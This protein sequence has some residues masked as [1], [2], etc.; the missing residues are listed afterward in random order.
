MG[1][2]LKNGKGGGYRTYGS[3]VGREIHKVPPRRIQLRMKM[4]AIFKVALKMIILAC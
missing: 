2:G 1:A 3:K 4:K